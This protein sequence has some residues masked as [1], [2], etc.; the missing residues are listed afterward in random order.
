MP[1]ALVRFAAAWAMPTHHDNDYKL[2]FSHP[3]MV[4]DLLLG[5]VP[6]D[7]VQA[8]R[9]E[10]LERVEAE[11]LGAQAQLQGTG[12]AAT[13]SLAAP[14]ASSAATRASSEARR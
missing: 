10:T 14:R 11:M 3:E 13:T 8:A 7:W 6:G 9:F 4:R 1:L 12:A 5:F 2:L